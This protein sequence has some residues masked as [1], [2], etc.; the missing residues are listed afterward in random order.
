MA[1]LLVL[2]SSLIIKQMRHGVHMPSNLRS[3]LIWFAEEEKKSMDDLLSLIVRSEKG[4]LQA[5]NVETTHRVAPNCSFQNLEPAGEGIPNE[6]SLP[7][8][9]TFKGCKLIGKYTIIKP[10][11]SAHESFTELLLVTKL[12]YVQTSY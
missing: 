9:T 11:L 1:Y 12:E 5:S 3:L 2:L 7:P 6:E 8:I 4:G 10:E